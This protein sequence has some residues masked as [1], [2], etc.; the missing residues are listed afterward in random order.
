MRPWWPS[1]ARGCSKRW[2]ALT[3]GGDQLHALF[4][5]FTLGIAG[6]LAIVGIGVGIAVLTGAVSRSIVF[7]HLQAYE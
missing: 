2:L 4:G 6:Y 7:R 1:P 3:P 5:T